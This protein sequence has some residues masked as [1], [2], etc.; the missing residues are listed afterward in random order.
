MDEPDA[1]HPGPPPDDTP[2][3][4]PPAAAS[5]GRDEFAGNAAVDPDWE[6]AEYQAWED[7]EIAAGRDPDSAP[8][9]PEDD[10][11]LDPLALDQDAGE[12][13]GLADPGSWWSP[14]PGR[15]PYAP[16]PSGPQPSGSGRLPGPSPQGPEQAPPP[17]VP[18]SPAADP[19]D[20]SGLPLFAQGGVGD[21]LPP[22]PK[23]TRLTDSATADPL[24]PSGLSDDE[25]IG[26][27][28]AARRQVAHEQYKQVLVIAEFGRRRQAAFTDA[29]RLG[30]PVGCRPGGFPGEELATEMVITPI[31]AGHRIDDALDLTSRLPRTLA[32]MAAGLIDEDRAGWISYYTRSL[33]DQDAAYADEV[34]AA[35]APDLRV[36]QLARKAAA[37]EKKLNPE[38]VKARRE[39]ARRDGQR[40]EARRE[41]SGNASL[42]GREMDTADVIASKAHI[43]AVAARLRRGGL[44][45]S[46]G[47]LRVLAMTDLTQGRNPL[48]RLRAPSPA[49]AQQPGSTVPPPGSTVPPPGPAGPAPLPG[50][51]GPAPLP[52]LVNVI[53]PVGTL[54]GWSTAPAE[55]GGWGLLDDDEARTV[56]A[57]AARHPRTRWCATVTAPDG[58]AVAHACA[59]GQHPH[60]LD[61]R[62]PDIP[63]PDPG[64][65]QA[66]GSPPGTAP[67]RPPP[68]AAGP[69]TELLQRLGLTFTPVARDICEHDHAETG[70]TPSR[71]LRHLVRARNATCDAPGC[72]AEA[73]HADLDHTHPW[74]DGP[75]DECNL[76]SRC[77]THHRAKQ[78]PDWTVEQ[79]APGVARWTMPSGRVHTT[80]P[81]RYDT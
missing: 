67:G 61:H 75:T 72:R 64:G 2:S 63:G 4:Y 10:G 29:A 76:A 47:S 42:S 23:L 35:V 24:G 32:G 46:L 40:V 25:L 41:L 49:P 55:A 5:E 14:P 71:K 57:A 9:G 70:Y 78:A 39:R 18:G 62:Y 22:G 8:W 21:R 53:I 11:P 31:D 54:L 44:P 81:T 37:L 30:L 20:A 7:R 65:P 68:P 16:Y 19:P 50:S 38:G 73:A 17:T 33:T 27:L 80:T 6:W 1:N 56:A 28:R 26:V 43:D 58:S 48:D 13:W 45:G 60:L 66:P 79:I 52:A 34:L 69:V 51:E 3:P 12:P 59:T 74:P 36:D 15:Y 77:R